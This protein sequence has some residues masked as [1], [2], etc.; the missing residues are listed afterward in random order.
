MLLTAGVILFS[1]GAFVGSYDHRPHLMRN[2]LS[3]GTLPSKRAVALLAVG[4]A[5]GLVLYAN[6]VRYLASSGPTNNAFVNLRYAAT[7]N[8]EETGGLGRVTYCR[9]LA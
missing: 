8:Y 9:L 6:R 4:V 3:E 5:L 7:E 2:Y 1:M